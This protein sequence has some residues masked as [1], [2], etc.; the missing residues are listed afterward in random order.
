M[1]LHRRKGLDTNELYLLESRSENYS[2]SVV[3]KVAAPFTW[4][5]E[6]MVSTVE[7]ERQEAHSDIAAS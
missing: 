6:P 2:K 3:G 5:I 4:G 7:S 1:R